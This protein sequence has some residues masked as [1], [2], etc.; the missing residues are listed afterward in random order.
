MIEA[1]EYIQR[2]I[3]KNPDNNLLIGYLVTT[4]G[5]LDRLPEAKE[6]LELFHQI[7]PDITSL[8]DYGKV[9]PEFAKEVILKGMAKAG[10]S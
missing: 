6:K 2:A 3:A 7:R 8:E 1:Y 5:N 10:L 9:V 4:L